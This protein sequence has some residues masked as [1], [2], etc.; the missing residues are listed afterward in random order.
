MSAIQGY[1]W[2]CNKFGKLTKEH[3]PPESAF[4]DCPL[5]YEKVAERS[6]QTG[7]VEWIPDRRQKGL[8]FH[9]LCAKCMQSRGIG[10]SYTPFDLVPLNWHLGD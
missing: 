3:I 5:L 2:L 4:N 8:Y 7:V 1:C 10:W 6:H 9:S